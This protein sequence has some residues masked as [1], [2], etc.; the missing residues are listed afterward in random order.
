MDAKITGEFIA[1]L[2]KGKN[3]TQKQ[4]AQ[5]IS[6]TDKAVSR[7]ETGKGYPDVTSLL[8]ISEI[9]D[10]SVNELLKGARINTDEIKSVTEEN[11][12]SVM[13]RSA[14]VLTVISKN[15]RPVLLPAR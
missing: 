7:W 1:Q 13:S 2:R 10:V 12:V 9:F 15:V 6:V 3:L 5:E 14:K 8:R 4:L 11:V